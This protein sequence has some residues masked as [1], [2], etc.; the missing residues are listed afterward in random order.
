[1][2]V[3][4]RYSV[5]VCLGGKLQLLY[6]LL[7]SRESKIALKAL[8]LGKFATHIIQR[9]EQCILSGAHQNCQVRMTLIGQAF[10]FSYVSDEH[11]RLKQKD[12][13]HKRKRKNSVPL[14][15]S[16]L[17]LN[18]RQNPNPQKIPLP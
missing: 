18:P 15:Q 17:R 5:Q 6:Y 14:I 16:S 3:R 12:S 7:V 11:Y 9:K 4:R 8:Q 1:M 10:S 13:K 2:A